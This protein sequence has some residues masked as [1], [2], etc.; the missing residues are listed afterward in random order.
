METFEE[1]DSGFFFQRLNTQGKR[2]LGNKKLPGGFGDV[3]FLC[4]SNYIFWKKKIRMS[5]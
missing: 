5:W 4:N 1:R 2:R 3:F